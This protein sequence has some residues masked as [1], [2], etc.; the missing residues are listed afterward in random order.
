MWYINEV[1]VVLPLLPVIH[2]I[3]ELVYRP[4]NSIS[5]IIGMLF[6]TISF[7]IGTSL[8]IPGLLITSSAFKINSAVCWPSSQGILRLFSCSLYLSFIGDLSETKT[9]KPC[10]C[11]NT[12]APIPLSAAPKITILAIICYFF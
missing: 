9:S 1:V 5:L 4:A 3:L 6:F 11:A 10:F 12:A 8:G 2:I 7:T